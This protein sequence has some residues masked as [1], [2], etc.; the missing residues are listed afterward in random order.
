VSDEISVEQFVRLAEFRA[1]LRS[2]LRHNERACRESGLTPQRYLL[3]LAI[4]GAPDGSERMSFSDL[5][6]RLQLSANTVTELCARA[7]QAGFV[8]REPSESDQR[9]TYLR[10]T[11]DGE[12]RLPK[13]GRPRAGRPG[14]APGTP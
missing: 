13:V 10:V 6:R 11:E 3:L 14:E 12:R 4:K 7:E 2:F 1:S 8:T 5:A 9:V